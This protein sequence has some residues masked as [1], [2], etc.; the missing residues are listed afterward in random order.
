M[1]RLSN[2]RCPKCGAA[3]PLE[4]SSEHATCGYCGATAFV[5]RTRA[6]PPGG[7]PVIVVSSHFPTLL[8]LALG[9]FAVL[10]AAGAV[11]VVAASSDPAPAPVAVIAPRPVV[12]SMPAPLPVPAAPTPRPA[13]RPELR[14]LSSPSARFVG[15]ADGAGA[16]IL[17]AVALTTGSE[18]TTAFAVFD[19]LTGVLRARTPA[20]EVPSDALLAAAAGRLVLATPNGQLT[21][22]DLGSGDAQWTTALGDRVVAICEGDEAGSMLVTTADERRLALDLVTG[23]QTE[24]HARC[25]SLLA[26][27]RAFDDPRDRH[28]Y[29]APP[30]VEAYR[31]GGVTVMG[32]ANFRVPDAC[33]A[34]AHVNTDRLDGMV[35]H[36]LWK[37]EDGWLVFGVRTPGT[38]VPM[39][40]R[41]ARGGRF[42]WK[43][44]VPATN[45]LEAEQGGPRYAALA[46]DALVVAYDSGGAP[47]W[48]VTAFGVADGARRFTVPL[49]VQALHGLEAAAGALFVHADEAIL[50]L[51]PATGALRA[52]VGGP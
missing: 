48:R 50:V 45:P 34:R 41:L 37:H 14:V 6:A 9:G 5:Q 20:L 19:G 52:T 31:C 26:A 33:L 12:P 49:E 28:D 24:T 15:A 47:R 7:V 39:V 8:A 4:P 40:G 11:L 17:A 46:G 43:S 2:G 22:Y 27:S 3:V 16:Q 1:A 42:A 35:G 51:D 21:G 44:E 18:R 30:G 13:E 36:R 32:S 10:V 23:R 25:G 38:Y 29:Q